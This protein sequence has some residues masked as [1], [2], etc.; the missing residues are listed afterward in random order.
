[1]LSIQKKVT[2][3]GETVIDG[4]SVLG[5]SATIDSDNPAEITISCWKNDK[6]LYK[7]H[8]SLCRQEQAEF[9]DAAYAV[10]DEII[11]EKG[12]EEETTE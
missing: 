2:L 3:T 11:S 8:R 10:Q 5:H 6:D 12:Q 9:E 7:Q 4:K 1:M